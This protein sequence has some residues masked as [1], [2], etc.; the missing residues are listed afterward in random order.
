M[1]HRNHFTTFALATLCALGL[2]AGAAFAKNTHP[3]VHLKTPRDRGAIEAIDTTAHT[4]VVKEANKATEQ[5]FAWDETTKFVQ[6]GK[7]VKAGD[8]KPGQQVRIF[9]QKR[10][11]QLVAQQVVVLAA[12]FAHQHHR[13]AKHTKS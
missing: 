3:G 7:P 11:D 4:L 10:G 9:Y 13:A 6:Q 2:A 12:D 8:L 5:R 1:T